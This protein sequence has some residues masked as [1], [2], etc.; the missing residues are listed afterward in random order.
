MKLRLCL[1]KITE[2]LTCLLGNYLKRQSFIVLSWF[3]FCGIMIPLYFIAQDGHMWTTLEAKT[4][5]Q[6]KK[7]AVIHDGEFKIMS[8]EN[9]WWYGTRKDNPPT[10]WLDNDEMTKALAE[11]SEFFSE[12]GVMAKF[13]KPLAAVA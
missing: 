10:A 3:V 12:V 7:V 6:Y 9:G 5:P 1:P 8:H 13:R 2:Y 11:A 4:P